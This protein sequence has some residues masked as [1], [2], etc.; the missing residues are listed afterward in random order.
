MSA[1]LE[2]LPHAEALEALRAACAAG[3]RS[4]VTLLNLAIARDRIGETD[5]AREMMQ[6]I[7][8][9]LPNWDEPQLRL[10]ESYRREGRLAD[11]LYA[12]EA[13]LGLN[14]RREEA[15]VSRAALLIQTGN[16]EAARAPLLRCVEINPDNGE[17][18][19]ALGIA[20]TQAGDDKKAER[21]FA[22]ATRIAPDRLNFALHRVEA[23]A[24]CGQIDEEVA[25]LQRAVDAD[26]LDTVALTALALAFD[27][28]GRWSE[29]VDVAEATA[30]LAP[31]QVETLALAGAL[32]ARADR[33]REAE[34]ML[35]HA[36]SLAPDNPEIGNDHGAVLLRLQRHAAA[37]EVLTGVLERQGPTLNVL[38]NLATAEVSLGLQDQAASTARRAVQLYPKDLYAH[39]TLLN[40][41]PYRYGTTGAEML[42]VAREL[43][44]LLPRSPAQVFANPSDPDRRLRLALLSGS[45]R[46]H[47]VGWLTISGFQNLDPALFEIVC[48]TQTASTDHLA[49]RFRAIASE[50]HDIGAMDN[51]SAASLARDRGVDILIDLG[52]HGDSGRMIVCAHRAAPV[53]IKWVGMQNHSTGLPEMDWIVADRWQI[54]PEQEGLYSERMLRLADGYVCY[55]PPAYAADVGPLPAQRNGYITFGCFNNLAKITPRT[56]EVWADILHRLPDSRLV[57]KTHQF[58]EAEPRSRVHEAFG[59]HGIAAGRIE[60]RGSSPHREFMGQ[61]NDVDLVLDPFPY[62]GGLTTCEALW[63]G[64][65]TVTL[66]G[67]TFS[68]RHSASHL[69]NAG[70]AD[71][72]AGDLDGYIRL[73]ISKASDQGALAELRRELRS[74]VKASPLCDAPRF[75]ASLAAGLRA[76]WRDWCERR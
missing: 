34:R 67:D 37:R 22:E 76:A 51:A 54:P 57:L 58:S 32:L 47:P 12:Y 7:A 59:Q 74:R 56:I 30:L 6:R 36:R 46:A 35:R 64:V 73:A 48:L 1:T 45:L 29:A 62:S 70:L 10:A 27:R 5:C 39:R 52:G 16:P 33:P 21:A 17:A 60:L 43:T 65:P 72:V 14:P 66:P 19:D 28:A 38:G 63:M 26:P 49:H 4:P 11:A 18:W 55:S 53:Q 15:L 20:L 75:G 31:E 2:Q 71:W 44:A 42:A 69:S 13:A 24:R 3:D 8:E 25:R 61:Y 9:A 41:I 50:W 40:T 68:S 23:A